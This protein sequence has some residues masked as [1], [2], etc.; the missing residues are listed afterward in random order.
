MSSSAVEYAYTLFNPAASL[1]REL[2]YGKGDDVYY[3]KNDTAPEE[4]WTLACLSVSPAHQKKGIGAELCRWGMERA[5]RER[6]C[7]FLHSTIAGRRLYEK[8]G[9]RI[10]GEW[11]WAKGGDDRLLTIMRWNPPESNKTIVGVEG[12]MEDGEDGEKLRY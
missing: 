2:S 12:P 8:V 5:R 7:A 9:F 10:V 11:R 3:S 6:V 1:P 4:C